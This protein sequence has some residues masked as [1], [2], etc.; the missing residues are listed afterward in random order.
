MLLLKHTASSR[1]NQSTGQGI[2]K[3]MSDYL[4]DVPCLCL[5]MDDKA[6]AQ[7]GFD[8][9]KGFIVY[10]NVGEDIK[11]GDELNISTGVKLKVSGVKSY[12]DVPPVSHMEI[13]CTKLES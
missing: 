1:R 12:Q 11:V 8:I 10:T 7:N 3:A 9:G 4:V 6:S 13:T 2:S 5:P